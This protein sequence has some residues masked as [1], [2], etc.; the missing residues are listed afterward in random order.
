MPLV[1]PTCPVGFPVIVWGGAWHDSELENQ[2]AEKTTLEIRKDEITSDMVAHCFEHQ[3]INDMLIFYCKKPWLWKW[4]WSTSAVWRCLPGGWL[5]F[6]PCHLSVP[7]IWWWMQPIYGP[8]NQ[9]FIGPLNWVYWVSFSKGAISGSKI[10]FER[11]TTQ[12]FQC[13]TQFVANVISKYWIQ[14]W[15]RLSIRKH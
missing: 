7:W 6:C 3:K 10:S 13:C 5:C 8:Q 4:N 1:A 14:A 11:W 2:T 15:S 9:W 12:W